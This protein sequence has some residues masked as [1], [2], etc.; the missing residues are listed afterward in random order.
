MLRLELIHVSKMSPK[1]VRYVCS[2]FS[3]YRDVYSALSLC[4]D[5]Y[6]ALSLCRDVYSAFAMSR[7]LFQKYHQG[8]SHSSPMGARYGCLFSPLSRHPLV[9]VA[10]VLYATNCNTGPQ[11]TEIRLYH[12]KQCRWQSLLVLGFRWCI[13][14]SNHCNSFEDRVPVDKIYGYPKLNPF[15]FI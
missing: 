14:K 10:V 4:R 3:L 5:V 1:K 15:F 12:I 7:S 8:T 11:Y 9:F 13:F 2:A 6:S